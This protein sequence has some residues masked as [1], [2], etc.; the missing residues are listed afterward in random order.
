MYVCVGWVGSYLILQTWKVSLV[1]IYGSF[2]SIFIKCVSSPWPAQ[3]WPVN[4]SIFKDHSHKDRP[5]LQ[6]GAG[7][8]DSQAT[9]RGY[10]RPAAGPAREQIS[11][12]FFHQAPMSTH[13]APAGKLPLPTTWQLQPPSSHNYCKPV[14][15]HCV[16]AFAGRPFAHSSPWLTRTLF[17][18]FSPRATPQESLCFPISCGCLSSVLP[19]PPDFESL[20]H[21]QQSLWLLS[22]VFGTVEFLMLD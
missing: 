18:P 9:S 5:W 13:R 7:L 3:P 4:C 21:P 1:F 17:S 20:R 10:S 12:S 11:P 15:G 8:P 14:V 22:V 16:T 2:V 6:E 19:Q